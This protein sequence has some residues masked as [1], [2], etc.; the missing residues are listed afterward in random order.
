M[1]PGK[2]KERRNVGVFPWQ[3]LAVGAAAEL[4]ANT[5][6]FFPIAISWCCCLVFV[7]LPL[8]CRLRG[9]NRA[10]N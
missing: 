2:V 8:S 10:L 1:L 7:T 6:F 5:A 4:H 3:F 9:D